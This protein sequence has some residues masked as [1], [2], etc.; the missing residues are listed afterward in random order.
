MTTAEKLDLMAQTQSH[1]DGLTKVL[2]SE[3]ERI[4]APIKVKLDKLQQSYDKKAEPLQTKIA[5]YNEAIRADIVKQGDAA[6][7]AALKQGKKFE[8]F[9]IKGD[10]VQGCYVK[11]RVS[12]DS[13]KLEALL[14]AYPAIKV[15]RN[16][17]AT[18]SVQIRKA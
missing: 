8:G 1:L 12:W 4:M 2:E 18:G 6:R 16:E 14:A 17:A 13:N 11:P 9:S 10:V 3:R 7:A 15:A 5:E